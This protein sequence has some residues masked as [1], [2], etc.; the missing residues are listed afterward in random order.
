MVERTRFINNWAIDLATDQ[1]IEYGAGIPNIHKLY[2][3][4]E[5]FE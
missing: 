5:T 4:H 3:I 1:G 2:S